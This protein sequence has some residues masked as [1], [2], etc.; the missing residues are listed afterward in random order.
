MK[1]KMHRT[2]SAGHPVEMGS[3]IE[4]LLRELRQAWRSLLRHKGLMATVLASLALGVGANTALFSV[5]D[6]VVLRPLPLKDGER[7]FAVRETRHG[8]ITGGNPQ[9]LYDWLAQIPSLE[10]AAAYYSE[11]L[12]ARVNGE[13]I[14]IQ[15]ARTF[16]DAFRTTGVYPVAGRGF[17]EDE[18]RGRGGAVTVLST[19]SARQ[20]FGDAARAV[21]QSFE[22]NQRPTTVIGVMASGMGL[23]DS[24]DA[25]MPAPASLQAGSRKA[26]FLFCFVRLRSGVTSDQAAAEWRVL[27]Q[28]LAA[29]YLDSDRG[30]VAHLEPLQLA[31]GKEARPLLRTLLLISGLVLLIACWNIGTLLL[32]RASERQR[33]ASIRKAMGGGNWDVMRLYLTESMLLAAIGSALGSC[34]AVLLLDILKS[35]LP[36]DLPRLETAAID[37]RMLLFSAGI[38]LICGLL[39]GAGPAWYAMRSPIQPSMGRALRRPWL[40]GALVVGE[41]AAA[42]A[43]LSGAGAVMDAFLRLR[44]TSLGFDATQIVTVKISQPWNTPKPRLDSFHAAALEQL[45]SLPGVRTAALVDRLPLEGGTQSQTVRIAGVTLPPALETRRVSL[46]GM[47]AGYFDSILIPYLRGTAL[48]RTGEAVVNEAF[49]KLYLNGREPVGQELSL[50]GG[51]RFRISGVAA[52]LRHDLLEQQQPEI[53]VLMEDVYW[54]LAHF[55]LR[56]TGDVPTLRRAVR[57]RIRQVDPGIWIDEIRT[58]EER[59]ESARSAP[60]LVTGFMSGFS[61]LALLLAAIGIHGLLASEVAQ[62]TREIGIRAALGADPSRIVREV[63]HRGMRLVWVGGAIGFVISLW[64]LPLLQALPLGIQDQPVLPRLVAVAVLATA[65][66]AA[67]GWPARRAA[68]IDPANTLRSE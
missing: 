52:D 6:A 60:Q 5:L 43:L 41:V 64:A 36:T 17:N 45:G 66:L 65:A 33:E 23:P 22:L 27:E 14:R 58:M 19:R 32:S 67:C 29:Q 13:P 50:E 1:V 44:N 20:L 38:S 10:S 7:V 40:S 3:G 61:L 18:M 56:A 2:Y 31:A 53:F 30:L 51:K 54:P 9:R 37:V 47:S 8:Q 59:I 11:Q 12:V 49:W 42:W 62:R 28:R 39:F 46:R 26:A 21:G 57:E 15:V 16:A 4:T 55:V 34:L 24:A 68:R 63:L 25:W 48:Q 35:A